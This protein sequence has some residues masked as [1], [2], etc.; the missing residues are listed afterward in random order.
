V[1]LTEDQI[2]ALAPDESSKKSGKDLAN[3]S[4]WITKGITEYRAYIPN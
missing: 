2:L 1:H 4:K 3:P